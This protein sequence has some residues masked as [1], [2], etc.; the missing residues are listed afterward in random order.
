MGNSNPFEAWIVII[1]IALIP[2][3]IIT[4]AFSDRLLHQSKNKEILDVL[5]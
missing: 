1:L 2:S 4:D 5:V 3:G